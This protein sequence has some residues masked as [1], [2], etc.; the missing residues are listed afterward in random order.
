VGTRGSSSHRGGGGSILPGR[1]GRDQLSPWRNNATA[2]QQILRDTGYTLADAQ[3]A[4]MT[5]IRYYGADYD[6]FTE[7]SLP[8]ETEI[9]SEAL[10]RMPYYNG[11]SIYRGISVP[12]RVADSVFL[13]TWK[14]GTVHYF[15]DKLGHGNAVV[16][17]FSSDEDVAESFGSWHW[18]PRG[19]TSI[20]FV[21]D[22]NKTA[23]GVQ[24]ISKFGTS[25]A[26]VLLPSFQH[27][28]VDRVV[29]M[30]DSSGGGR[31][32]EIHLKDRGRKKK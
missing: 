6:A 28:Y 12:D 2:L 19:S 21:M 11:G 1:I 20:K 26:E 9:I 24:H 32:F 8:H 22:D 7:G 25:E 3:L 18:V 16:Q 30:S 15:T 5:Q 27:V 13:D 31:R 17:S 23:P 29:Q 10:M 4:Q 14:P